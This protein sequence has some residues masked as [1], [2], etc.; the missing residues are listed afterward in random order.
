MNLLIKILLVNL[1]LIF[2]MLCISG[3][4]ASNH[5]IEASPLK[6]TLNSHLSNDVYMATPS[7]LPMLKMSTISD[8]KLTIPSITDASQKPEA[9]WLLNGPTSDFQNIEFRDLIRN[10]NYN[11]LLTPFERRKYQNQVLANLDMERV[12][13]QSANSVLFSLQVRLSQYDIDNQKYSMELLQDNKF[14]QI[15]VEES[16]KNGKRNLAENFCIQFPNLTLNKSPYKTLNLPVNEAERIT[17]IVP[18][19]NNMLVFGECAIKDI[20]PIKSKKILGHYG[21][22]GSDNWYTTFMSCP[23]TRIHLVQKNMNHY[24]L[25]LI[26]ERIVLATFEASSPDI[27][28]ADT[29]IKNPKTEPTP[30]IKRNKVDPFPKSESRKSNP[31]TKKPQEINF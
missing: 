12:K 30:Q 15:F 1:T 23:I 5:F 31:T 9:D 6:F 18:I 3:E 10:T 26:D 13:L 4:S 28:A 7:T 14:C 29:E 19:T 8:A 21:L 25:P 24:V 16:I 11:E 22:V 17:N 2:P 27:T 20:T